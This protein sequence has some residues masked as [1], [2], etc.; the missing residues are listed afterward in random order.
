MPPLSAP[1]SEGIFPCSASASAPA[2][3]AGAGALGKPTG[4]TNFNVTIDTTSF[5]V[6]KKGVA[7]NSTVQDAGKQTSSAAPGMLPFKVTLK[8]VEPVGLPKAPAPAPEAGAE[9]EAEQGN[10][11][12]DGG[13]DSGGM[14]Q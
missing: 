2:S 11:P 4:S 12:S 5:T 9:A 6:P 10:M 1:P 13:A 3:G 8:L 7:A 14:E